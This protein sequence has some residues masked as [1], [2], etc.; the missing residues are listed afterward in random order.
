MTTGARYHALTP[1]SIGKSPHG[2]P[3]T[4]GDHVT[5]DEY[6]AASESRRAT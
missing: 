6:T 3:A 5:D 4:W 2:N 1:P